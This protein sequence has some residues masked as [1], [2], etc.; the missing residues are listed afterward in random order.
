[1]AR[2]ADVPAITH[3]Y[4]QAIAMRS[5]TADMSP[6][7]AADRLAWLAEHDPDHYPVYVA[8]YGN[9]VVGWCSLSAYRP[10]RNAL[11]HTA[12]ISYYVD[13]AYRGK[14][15][16][17]ALIAHAIAQCEHVHIRT[18][19]AILLDINVDSTRIL[20]RFGFK[21]WGHMLNVADFDGEECGHLYY[22]LRVDE[23]S[24]A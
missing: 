4:N 22:G 19:F 6:L 12:E 8:E 13:Q 24:G 14:G 5:A 9:R 20:E 7:S 3:I 23:K 15:V 16:G 18:L 2:E 1:M 21:K 10:G 11:R 17:S